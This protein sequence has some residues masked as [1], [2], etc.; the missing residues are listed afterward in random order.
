MPR[1]REM[2]AMTTGLTLL[3]QDVGAGSVRSNRPLRMP[4]PRIDWMAKGQPA[5]LMPEPSHTTDSPFETGAWPRSR[6][7][8]TPGTSLP[9]T[10]FGHAPDHELPP[11]V[12]DCA[13]LAPM[14][15]NTG[16]TRAPVANTVF[17]KTHQDRR[18]PLNSR[19]S[20]H[21]PSYR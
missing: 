20:M 16:R 17:I 1:S 4:G 11:G 8:D 2:H 6:A 14:S 10:R 15:Q 7:P 5:E 21:G 18:R 19:K 12:P 9:N 3:L 13:G